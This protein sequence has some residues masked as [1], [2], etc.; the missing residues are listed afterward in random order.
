MARFAPQS[1]ADSERSWQLLEVGSSIWRK[2]D[3][4]EWQR[5]LTRLGEEIGEPSIRVTVIGGAAIALCFPTR[6]TTQDVDAIVQNDADRDRLFAAVAK[7]AEEFDLPDDWFNEKANAAG[8][9]VTEAFGKLEK[10]REIRFVN[11]TIEIPSVLHMM[12]M[13]LAA[14]RDDR[15]RDD[16]V[17]LLRVLRER[18]LEKDDVMSLVGGL[19]PLA[20]REAARYDLEDLWEI[21]D[22]SP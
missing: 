10:Q 19:M 9:L 18:G 17:L 12:A 2:L 5:V 3:V 20:K 11:L 22:E 16:A 15:D 8:L 14:M 21:T 7:V 4:D 1:V 6:R 13:K